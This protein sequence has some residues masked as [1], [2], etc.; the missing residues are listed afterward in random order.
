MHAVL[1]A[2]RSALR[3]CSGTVLLGVSGGLDSM[4]ML[5][6][7]AK[8]AAALKVQL[9]VAHLDHAIRQSSPQDAAFV[10]AACRSL[11]VA[12]YTRR[13]PAEPLQGES[14]E[15]AARRVRLG[16]FKDAAQHHQAGWLMLAHHGDDQAETLLWRLLRGAGSTGLAG[17]A[18][19]APF[20]LQDGPT[21]LR[22]FLR[23][24][25]AQLEDYCAKNRIAH[26][27]DESNFDTAM[28]R[29][30]IR[31]HLLPQLKRDYGVDVPTLGITAQLLGEED[32]YLA[33]QAQL[34][35]GQSLLD[36][37]V[38]LQTLHSAP[39]ALVRRA[40]MQFLQPK[41]DAPIG[42]AHVEAVRA[43]Q[44]GSLD[45]P[46]KLRVS[47]QN[48]VLAIDQGCL[49][50]QIVP[51]CLP[52]R[53][54][55]ATQTPYGTL[56]AARVDALA[57][58]VPPRTAYLDEAT[59]TGA[60]V[61]SRQP[62]DRYHALGAPGGKKLKDALIDRKIDPLKRMWP[63]IAIDKQVLWMPGLPPSHHARVRECT[64]SIVRLTWQ[65][66]RKNK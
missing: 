44:N 63:V 28:V 40:L 23:L 22:P 7:A 12:L 50:P 30:C 4:A 48:G 45:L 5:D 42:F 51:Y 39:V 10:D 38:S 21:L 49:A 20:P 6:A 31:H 16:F 59:L 62:G 54:E 24:T 41:T 19:S 43:L 52:L 2:M 60:L 61:R 47:C 13:I 33:Q 56:L 37:G 29:N 15:M 36:G 34:L 64:R 46:G 1:T 8:T 9:A 58:Q 11:G 17:M 57:P 26:V 27:Q 53:L 35:L 18:A 14:L 32:V 66:D 65:P 25:R 3:A 55:G